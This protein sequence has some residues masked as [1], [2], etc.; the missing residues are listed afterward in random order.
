MQKLPWSL[1]L[2]K[3]NLHAVPKDFVKPKNEKLDQGCRRRRQDEAMTWE[4]T[5]EWETVS[6][7]KT[8]P[9]M[10]RRE[11]IVMKAS[12]LDGMQEQVIQ[13]KCVNNPKLMM[14]MIKSAIL[15]KY[16]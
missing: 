12:Q 16:F 11:H 7:N 1:R 5:S 8:A 3:P 9:A 2:H 14:L 15:G 10:A 6:T 13:A 4:P